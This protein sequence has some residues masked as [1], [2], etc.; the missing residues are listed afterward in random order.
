MKQHAATLALSA[1]LLAAT[2]CTTGTAEPSKPATPTPAT[3][4]ASPSELPR[5][6]RESIA[7]A[8]GIPPKP[9]GAKRAELLAKLTAINP[10]IGKDEDKAIDAA[11][12][13][14]QSINRGGN[15]LDW[16][17]AQRFSYRGNEVS[18]AEGKQINEM[19]KTSGFCKI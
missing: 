3:T 12:N 2:A 11:R 10:G 15:K 5:E 19:L 4:T 16:M 18:E 7:A 8:A 17:A 14:C 1:L 6:V 9:T 13:Q